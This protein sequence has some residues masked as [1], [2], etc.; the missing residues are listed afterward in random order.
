MTI[1]IGISSCLLGNEVRYDGGHKHSTLCTKTLSDFFE[2]VPVCPEV[3]IGLPI[4]RPAIQ[5]D[6][7]LLAPQAVLSSDHAINYTDR[8]VKYGQQVVEETSDLSGYIF[9]EKSPSCGL[10]SVTIHAAE[11]GCVIGQGRGLYAKVITDAYPFLPVEESGRLEDLHIRESFITR[12]FA[13]SDW[14]QLIS[15]EIT[16]PLLI[17]FYS[18]YKYCLMAHDPV[19]YLL[20]GSLLDNV[21]AICWMDIAQQYFSAL[22]KSLSQLAT[23]ESHT[24]VLL[25][26][27]GYVKN[28]LS[29]DENAELIKRIDRYR[30]AE[31][32]L[33]AVKTFLRHHVK[34]DSNSIMLKQV[35]LQAYIQAG[36]NR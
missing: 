8:L 34:N 2:F 27:Q 17:D 24:T 19:K 29:V 4:P 12:V 5:L 22:M 23:Q 1:K 11:K 15:K 35:Y 33:A 31:I 21:N 3:G 25:A 18:R 13:Y 32:P 28:S 6:G 30:L 20:L 9:M 16:Q 36:A 7:C 10:F 14:Q 26:I